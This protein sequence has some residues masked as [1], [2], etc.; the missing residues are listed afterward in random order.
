[1]LPC[2]G[3]AQFSLSEEQK[4]GRDEFCSL[5]PLQRLLIL[6]LRVLPR[7]SSLCTGELRLSRSSGR[8]GPSKHYTGFGWF[9]FVSQASF[10]FCV[11]LY[12]CI[13]ITATNKPGSLLALFPDLIT[14]RRKEAIQ[15]F[16]LELLL[17]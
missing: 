7:V 17:A 13:C 15:L 14:M 2:R 1:M 3:R 6:F 5:Q 9:L 4:N 12:L 10:V 11:C 8:D 16:F